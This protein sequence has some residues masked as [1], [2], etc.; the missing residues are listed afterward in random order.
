M[1]VCYV[2][3]NGC[4]GRYLRMS[5]GVRACMREFV[6]AYARLRTRSVLVYRRVGAQLAGDE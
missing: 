1:A 2:I 5:V 4:T 6:L 3:K